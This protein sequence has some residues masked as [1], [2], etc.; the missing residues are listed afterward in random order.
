MR[1]TFNTP[2]DSSRSEPSRILT[3]ILPDDDW[4]TFSYPETRHSLEP[5][6]TQKQAE[7]IICGIWYLVT[8]VDVMGQ[9]VQQRQRHPRRDTL[10]REDLDPGDDIRPF[11]VFVEL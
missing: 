5:N 4:L 10:E 6:A 1:L 11:V 7:V 2:I 9:R 8:D 3:S